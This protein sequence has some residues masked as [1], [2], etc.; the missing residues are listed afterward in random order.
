[1]RAAKRKLILYQGMLNILRAFTIVFTNIVKTV[2]GDSQVGNSFEREV[3]DNPLF[4]GGHFNFC[5][6]N[7]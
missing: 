7:W 1:M 6:F 5:R 3:S 4:S 2:G